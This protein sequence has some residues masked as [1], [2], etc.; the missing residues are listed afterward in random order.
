MG[1]FHATPGLDRIAEQ[2]RQLA[3]QGFSRVPTLVQWM[4]TGAC[5]GACSHCM[6]SPG[7]RMESLSME[8][9]LGLMDEIADW[10]VE[11]FLLT[12]GEPLDRPDLP[13]LIEALGV[14]RI[15]WSLNTAKVPAGDVL[16]AMEQWPPVFAAV[17]LDGPK[18]V[19]DAIR[20]WEGAF[21]G[22]LDAIRILTR[23]TGGQVA[24]GTTVSG[25]NFS[26][27]EETFATVVASGA[28]HWGLHLVVPDGRAAGQPE[29]ELTGGQVKK[30]IRFC[31]DKRQYFPVTLADELGYCGTFEPLVRDRPFFCGA[32][33]T[34]CVVLPNGDVTACTSFAPEERQGNIRSHSL[35]ELW[36]NA[37][38]E[39]RTESLPDTCAT[40]KVAE[41]CKGG[42]RLMRRH[43]VHCAKPAWEMP[44]ATAAQVAV[45]LGLAACTPAAGPT[46]K[47]GNGP[48]LPDPVEQVE[49]VN[50]H[51]ES[52]KKNPDPEST[53][54]EAESEA[55]GLPGLTRTDQLVLNWY[56]HELYRRPASRAGFPS[57]TPLGNDPARPFLDDVFTHRPRPAAVQRAAQ[58]QAALTTPVPS[59]HLVS[60]VWRDLAVWC[61]DGPAPEKR[62]GEETRLI[63]ETMETLSKTTANW[64][65]KI[66]SEKLH[67]FLHRDDPGMRRSFLSKAGP[68]PLVRLSIWSGRRHFAADTHDQEIT[69]EWLKI[70]PF[71]TSMNLVL[72]LPAKTVVRNLSTGAKP[73]KQMTIGLF[74]ILDT[75]KSP[76]NAS[77][78]FGNQTLTVRLPPGILTHPDLLR[79]AYEQ[80]QAV[81][82]KSATADPE[83]EAPSPL[84]IPALRSALKAAAA[85]SSDAHR[86]RH[87]LWN[88][89]LF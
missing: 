12:G 78:A 41:A 4:V 13:Q 51:T 85:D 29:L 10:G 31:A 71:A 75:G 64:R 3:A 39:L 43:K 33:R 73:A 66:F 7:N 63:R 6:T 15:R 14:R 89:W 79:L 56:Q 62:S 1:T 40:C 19:H 58:L 17:S 68:P 36:E 60:L 52:S 69:A 20:G 16:G 84:L 11:E 88:A 26:S 35:R 8:D 28:S 22:A 46:E 86:F 5:E 76:V 45:C 77:M 9:A 27:L 80:N 44:R 72:T 47:P 38:V 65:Q 37:F 57:T 48:K 25:R 81:L 59:L 21:D 55:P 82:D 83:H 54:M 18:R 74:D 23:L 70:H 53:D 34:S 42:C 67:P 2:N 50:P 32:G 30:L 87:R 61:M 24:A 49:P